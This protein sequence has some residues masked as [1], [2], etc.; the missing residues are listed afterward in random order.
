MYISRNNGINF[1]EVSPVIIP[2]YHTRTFDKFPF[3]E[4]LREWEIP[5]C[6]CQK[7]QTNDSCPIQYI[8]NFTGGQFDLINSMGRSFRTVSATPKLQA[9]DNPGFWA[10]EGTMAFTG[11]QEGVYFIQISNSGVPLMISEPIHIKEFWPNTLLFQVRNKRFHNDVIFETGIV[12]NFRVEGNLGRNDP[13]VFEQ[14]FSDQRASQYILS[15]RQY[16]RLLLNVGGNRGVPDWVMDKM[17]LFFTCSDVGIDGRLYAKAS[18]GEFE[19]V[20]EEA[21]A[22][23]SF[24]MLVVPGV[25][26][27]SNIINP[28]LNVNARLSVIYNI[29]TAAIYGNMGAPDDNT[30]TISQTE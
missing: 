29:R 25:N 6:Y 20:E 8:A 2:Q 14:F 28:D 30:I 27:V 5:A 16:T 13:G 22:L 1:Y 24:N 19:F 10:Q 18:E 21:Y 15:G 4:T 12:F 11:M 7:F 3:R 23:R 9:E 17:S 26:R